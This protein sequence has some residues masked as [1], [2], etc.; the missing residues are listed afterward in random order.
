[1]LPIA[2][3]EPDIIGIRKK[4]VRVGREAGFYVCL[5]VEKAVGMIKLMFDGDSLVVIKLLNLGCIFIYVN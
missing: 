5:H 3:A 4:K 1:M 2:N